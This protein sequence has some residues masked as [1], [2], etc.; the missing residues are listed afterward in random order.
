M[1]ERLPRLS[2]TSAVETGNHRRREMTT[3]EVGRAEG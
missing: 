2:G 1:T 3:E